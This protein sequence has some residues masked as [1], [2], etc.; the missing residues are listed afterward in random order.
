MTERRKLALKSLAIIVVTAVLIFVLVRF[1]SGTDQLLAAAAAARWEYIWAPIALTGVNVLVASYRWLKIVEAMGYQVPYGQGMR[2]IL[3]AFPVSVVTPARAGD[4]L[5]A[6]HIRDRVPIVAGVGSA[7]AEKVV[8]VNSLCLLALIGAAA[9]GHWLFM[10]LAAGMLLGLYLV[11]FLLVR[12]RGVML[13]FGFINKRAEKFENLFAAFDALVA[14]PRYLIQV[15]FLSLAAWVNVLVS[16]YLLLW[17]SGAS[18]SFL[19]VVSAWPLAVFV[20][21]VPV[22][23][24]GMGTRDAAFIYLATIGG[25]VQISTTE[26]LL[27]TMTYTLVTAWLVSAVGLPYMI[28]ATLAS[29]PT[30]SES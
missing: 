24:A 27:A 5:R 22:T 21:L 16:V 11:V 14:K 18:M 4:L 8:D 23:M 30:S 20:G 9:R 25:A 19:F 7:L 26:T 2:A 15:A 1:L 3:A 28:R 13:R 10:G 17:I 6:V 12:Y 29:G